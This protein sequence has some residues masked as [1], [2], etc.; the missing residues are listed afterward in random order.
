MSTQHEFIITVAVGRGGAGAA[1]RGMKTSGK[2]ANTTLSHV[3]CVTEGAEKEEK[4]E[5]HGVDEK[6][7]KRRLTVKM[8]KE[9]IYATVSE[10]KCVCRHTDDATA[11]TAAF[12]I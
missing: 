2:Y 7:K 4:L 8:F 6:N 12:T 10:E 1:K 3:L 5:R 11:A 9:V